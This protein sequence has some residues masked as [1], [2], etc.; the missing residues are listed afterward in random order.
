MS[1]IISENQRLLTRYLAA[2]G[3]PK[4]NIIHIS[5]TLW[6]EDEV[7][8]MLEFCA[9]NPDASPAQ[10]LKVCSEISS[11]GPKSPEE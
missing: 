5:L 7:L 2:V 8:E 9:R 6:E 3:C 1:K 11:K 10:L 4:S